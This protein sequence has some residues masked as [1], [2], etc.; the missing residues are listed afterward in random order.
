M[1][2]AKLKI[3]EKLTLEIEGKTVEIVVVQTVSG[4]TELG[5]EAPAEVKVVLPPSRGGRVVKESRSLK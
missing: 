4:W 5:L 1:R 2:R 3:G